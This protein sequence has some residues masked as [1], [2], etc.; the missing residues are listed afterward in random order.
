VALNGSI[1]IT[2]RVDSGQATKDLESLIGRVEKL[3]AAQ[4]DAAKAAANQAEQTSKLASAS[5]AAGIAMGVFGAA[6][7]AAAIGSIK[8][9]ADLEQSRV[10][11]TTLLGSGEKARKFLDELAAFAA[12]TPFEFKDL[13]D[14]S[15]RLLAF[16]FAAKDIIPI[17]NAV[18][19]AVAGLGGGKEQIDRVTLALGQMQ[20][21]GKVSAE[22]MNQI[23]E[24]GVPGWE[25]IAKAI[26]KSIPE[27]MK[28]A[29]KGA[30][31]STTAINALITGMNAKF[32]G[33]LEKQSQTING[34]LSNLRDGVTLTATLIGEKLISA[35]HIADAVGSA[36][37]AVSGFAQIVKTGG[38]GEALETMFPPGLRAVLIG[39]AGAITA[40]LVPALGALAVSFGAATVAAGPFLAIGAGIGA[41]AYLIMQNWEPVSTFFYGLFDN[42][43]K[44][45]DA[46]RD[47]IVNALGGAA[48]QF[49]GSGRTAMRLSQGGA[50]IA[51]PKPEKAVA[52]GG[53]KNLLDQFMPNF[54]K[55]MNTTVTTVAN[56][57]FTGLSG[58]ASDTAA[59][60]VKAAGEKA[61]KAAAL[62]VD[63]SKKLELAYRAWQ[64][65]QDRNDDA[66]RLQLEQKALAERERL[67]REAQQRTASGLREAYG[68]A[69]NLLR[70]DFEGVATF[71]RGK[72][73]EGVV[74]ALS[75]SPAVQG[76]I[77]QLGAAF[78]GPLG[79]A[80]LFGSLLVSSVLSAGEQARK[81]VNQIKTVAEEADRIINP[82]KYRNENP[83]FVRVKKAL[84]QAVASQQAAEDAIVNF[85][86][87]PAFYF[88]ALL[89]GGQ[90]KELRGALDTAK[91][92]VAGLS[93]TLATI[94]AKLMPGQPGYTGLNLPTFTPT[95]PMTPRVAAPETKP[96]AMPGETPDRPIYTQV[97]NVRDF[98]EAFP[99]S[100]YFRAPSVD[101][102]RSLNANAVA[103]R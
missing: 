8:L 24:L 9:A 48:A 54:Q 26:G 78:T 18:G 86:K 42:I 64:A 34:Q 95:E 10:A 59:G 98:R 44:M 100:A 27:A 92:T 20:A 23:A 67:E 31:D 60:A 85:Q 83:E 56:T 94:P 91:N 58:K 82:E 49:G 4:N 76:A 13:Q 3:E 88:D 81:V 103:Y 89:G 33:M 6:M 75:Q 73:E 12:A 28:L 61:S 19:S 102:T 16:G 53:F 47:R 7:A 93:G 79:I 14:S 62:A 96:A 37:R 51:M 63:N 70:G 32:P 90:M 35:F 72:L 15:R 97:V 55:I 87:S 39:V 25:M 30:I 99:D 71:F 36:A 65:Q 22:E 50:S 38:L 80:A 40:S 84:D 45:A 68:V 29:E 2:T 43:A 74:N 1:V 52:S 66:E 11:F 69:L 21:K 41:A 17:M 77:S 5:N 57:A 101:T 46:V